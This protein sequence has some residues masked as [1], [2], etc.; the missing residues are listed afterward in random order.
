MDHGKTM[1]CTGLEFIDMQMEL[2]MKDNMKMIRKPGMV[3]IN[4]QM[5]GFMRDIGTKV[6]SMA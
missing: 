1:T 6:N 2:Y 4:G 5:E 3:Y